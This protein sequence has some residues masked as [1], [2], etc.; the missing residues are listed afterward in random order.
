MKGHEQIDITSTGQGTLAGQYLRR[1]WH[2]I[3]LGEELLPG[4]PKRIQIMGEHFTLYRGESGKAYVLAD[5]CAHRGTQL[6]LGWVEGDCIRCFYHGWVYDGSGQCIEQPAEKD[7][8]AGKVK[9][10]SCSVQEYLGLIFVYF[11]DGEPPPLPRFP[12]LEDENNGHLVGRAVNVPCNYFQRMENDVDET[13]IHFVHREAT[14]ASGLTALPDKISVVETDY[15]IYRETV[16][17]QE[18]TKI[19]TMAHFLMPNMMLVKIAPDIG[20]DR[21]PTFLGW[22]VPV[23]DESALN[24]FVSRSPDKLGRPKKRSATTDV[25]PDPRQLTATILAGKARVQDVDPRYRNIAF[26]VQDN[27]VLSG[28]GLVYRRENERLGQSDGPVILL[29]KLWQRELRALAD[30]QPLKDW[31]RPARK[32]DLGIEAKSQLEAVGKST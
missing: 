24:L 19:V 28:Q 22:R 30:G 10:P 21:W 2:P 15:G 23:D 11:G 26:A 25:L 12:E 32:L 31:R 9:V 3:H 14:D 8:F 16:R 13:H 18:G 27:V 7:S 4:R 1:F 17:T 29:R 5:R 6:S 20:D